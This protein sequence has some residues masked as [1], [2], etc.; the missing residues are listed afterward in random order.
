MPGTALIFL[1][2]PAFNFWLSH[3]QVKSV[4]SKP[5]PLAS[6]GV[7]PA[8]PKRKHISVSRSASSQ[9][10]EYIR[11]SIISMEYAP[12]QMIPETALAEQFGVSR[13]P[14]REA[15]IGLSNIGFVEVK[16]QRGTY[17]SKFSIEKILEAR[18]VREALEVAV[19]SSLAE[20]PPAELIEECERIIEK[21]AIAADKD[22]VIGFQT[23]DDAFHQALANGTGYARVASLIEAEKAHMDRVRS[24]SLLEVGQYKRVLNQHKAILQAIKAGSPEKAKT[25]M[26][27]HMK[28]VFKILSVVPQE[29]PEYFEDYRST[30]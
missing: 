25:A 17:V 30:L 26:E 8:Q 2:I 3:H 4:T 22:D 7:E 24:L 29:H 16:P 21:Q 11:D 19:A 14:V 12:G 18:F 20:K 15:L 5:S 6:K 23:L 1:H 27:V 9:I 10:Y 13:T 28:E